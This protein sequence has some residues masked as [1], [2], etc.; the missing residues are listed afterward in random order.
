[1]P[2]KL[3][4]A[5]TSV[6]TWVARATPPATPARVPATPITVPCTTKIDRMPD[7]L[8]PRVRRIAMSDSLSVTTMI[9]VETRLNAATATMRVRITNITVFSIFSARKKFA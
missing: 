2:K 7:W 6:S 8:A 1:M 5:G 4:M 3:S 9:R